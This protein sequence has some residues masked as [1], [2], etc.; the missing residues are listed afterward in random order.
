MFKLSLEKERKGDR[1]THRH[2]DLLFTYSGI[3]GRCSCASRPG[4][5]PTALANR[6]ETLTIGTTW[7]GQKKFFF[8]PV[9]LPSSHLPVHLPGLC[10]CPSGIIQALPASYCSSP[11]FIDPPLTSD[12]ELYPRGPQNPIS[13]QLRAPPAHNPLRL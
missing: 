12:L 13:G 2:I 8:T 4:I 10:I 11:A 7:P 1:R 5:E 9:G 6:D 3:H